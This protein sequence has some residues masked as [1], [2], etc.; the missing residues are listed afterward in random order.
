[1][2][3]LHLL[4]TGRTAR[5]DRRDGRGTRVR[6]TMEPGVLRGPRTGV[7]RIVGFPAGFMREI[8]V[9]YFIW[10]V[11]TIMFVVKILEFLC[12]SAL[13]GKRC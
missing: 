12:I 3:N 2:E 1:V 6:V 10:R 11:G 7:C 9:C 8:D 13:R 5:E 4:I